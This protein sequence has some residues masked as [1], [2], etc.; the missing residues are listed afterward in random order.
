[1]G[2]AGCDF[3]QLPIG[4]YLADLVVDGVDSVGAALV[5]GL[6]AGL[7]I[8]ASEWFA[9]R[10]W[11]SWL[12]IAA[13]SIGRAAGLTVGAALVNY[14]TRRGDLVLTELTMGV[15]CVASNHQG[16]DFAGPVEDLEGL[17]VSKQSLHAAA[18]M[19]AHG[20]KDLDRFD[21]VPH[22]RVGA[23][24]LCLGQQDRVTATAEGEA[25]AGGQGK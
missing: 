21:G 7:V 2:L 16:V 25:V 15:E 13:T 8:G 17:A 14:G 19:D 11:V 3:G 24:Q 6:I 20:T 1:V 9:L 4:G 23:E 10:G 18:E 12:W 5:G 22:G